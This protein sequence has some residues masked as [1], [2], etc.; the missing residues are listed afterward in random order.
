VFGNN[1]EGPL[2]N[3]QQSLFVAQFTVDGDHE[4]PQGTS[5][6]CHGLCV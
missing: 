2:L 6:P 4:W 1:K 5:N 3:Q